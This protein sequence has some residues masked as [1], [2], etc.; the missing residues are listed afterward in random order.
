[1]RDYRANV[2]GAELKWM[3]DDNSSAGLPYPSK[4]PVVPVSP[5]QLGI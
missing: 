2:L 5:R 1:M 3:E 4:T